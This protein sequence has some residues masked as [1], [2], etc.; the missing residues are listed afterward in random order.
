GP[1][2]PRPRRRA[3][4]NMQRPPPHREEQRP[5]RPRGL[6]DGPVFFLRLP[7]RRESH[8]L[9]RRAREPTRPEGNMLCATKIIALAG[10]CTIPRLATLLDVIDPHDVRTRPEHEGAAALLP[11]ALRGD[12]ADTRRLLELVSPAI[13]RLVRGVLGPGHVDVDDVI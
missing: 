12:R 1:R 3:A 5:L 2:R 6:G 4:R 13:G 10:P 7:G 11:G 9:E 8:D